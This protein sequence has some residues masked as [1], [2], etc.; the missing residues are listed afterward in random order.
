MKVRRITMASL[1]AIVALILAASAGLGQETPRAKAPVTAQATSGPT[2]LLAAVPFDRIALVDGTVVDVEP[3][4]PRPL[5]PYEASKDR[6]DDQGK[7]RSKVQRRPGEREEPKQLNAIVVRP[8]GTEE[9]RDF[10]L[11]RRNIRRLDYFEDLLLA[12]GERLVK[13]R[14][15]AG[16]FEHY[17]AVKA[18]DPAWKG[19]A[20]RV[21]ALLFE[22]GNA[23]MGGMTPDPDRGLRLL[24]ELQ[25]RRPDY[26]G[27]ADVLASAYGGRIARAFEAGAFAKGRRVL[28]D[29]EALAPGHPVA[30]EATARFVAKA[31]GLMDAAKAKAGAERVD[32][33]AEALRAWPGLEG[34]APAYRE[35]FAAEPTL[36]VAVLDAVPVP[37]PWPRSPAEERAAQLVYLPILAESGEEAASGGRPDQL[38][39][40]VEATDLGRR[41]LIRVRSG[42]KWSDDSRAVSAADVARSL[43]D[44]ADRAS[45]G[46][47]ARWADLLRRVDAVDE[48]RVEVDLE[49]AVLDPFARLLDP[50]GPGHADRAGLVAVSG[51]APRPVGDGPF[52]WDSGDARATTYR[53][54]GP[55]KV[56]RIVEVRQPDAP[57]AIAALLRGE[58]GLVERVPPD[59]VAGLRA[60]PRF[61]VGR[62]ATPA[63]H[64]IAVDGRN[65]QLRN[66]KLRRALSHA[67]DRATLLADV[68]LRHPPAGTDAVSDGPFVRGTFADAPDV[69]PLAYDPSLARMLAAVA[70]RELGLAAIKLRFEYPAT[71]EARA[72][73]P[74]LAE[75]FRAA[76]IA[77]DAVERPESELEAEL[78]A[79]RE[80]ELAY[81]ADR[82]N[83][84]ASDVGA[85]ICPGYDGPDQA[86][87][88]AS[89]ASPRIL[90]LLLELDRVPATTEARALLVRIDRESRDELPIIPLWQVEDHF[91]WR[92]Q[93]R[94]PREATDRLYRGVA[95]WEVDAWLPDD[96]P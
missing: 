19:L 23:A 1:P 88:F 53:A 5:P 22:E 47:R 73:A 54:S 80:F 10:R 83:G 84:P 14:N 2:D 24:A 63:L 12:E 57:S 81:R 77:I 34:A 72:A 7:S 18:R 49:R 55:A 71:P 13:A 16:A 21:D 46:Y 58:V 78:R 68:V 64:R 42:V 11:R 6:D 17:L 40:N 35:A 95:D 9:P 79:G 91:A 93:V 62:F 87:A 45:P 86:G 56:R 59:R 66:R 69:A 48:S 90:Q 27:L 41:L 36:R 92:A 20:E 82:P 70:R 74:K 32:L 4:T 30:A 60:D 50:V 67:I 76:G 37:S 75:A 39:E 89:L 26:P 8:R 38:A 65:P 52:R 28:R 33:L 61:K 96:Q 31:K 15:F 25:R 51:G 85:M 94:G 43:A 29:L 44:R 3:V